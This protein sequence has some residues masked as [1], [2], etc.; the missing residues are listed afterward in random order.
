VGSEEELSCPVFDLRKQGEEE[1]EGPLYENL[2]LNSPALSLP[3]PVQFSD[4]V[5]VAN[6]EE[7][8][9][10]EDLSLILTNQNPARIDV[11]TL[12]KKKV[13][14]SEFASYCEETSHF[15][16]NEQGATG[17]EE[18][19]VGEWRGRRSD[20]LDI[21]EGGDTI[22]SVRGTVR[23]VKNRVRAGIATFLQ[24]QTAKNY[25]ESEQGRCVV[26]VT[27]IGIV[28]ETKA[29][30]TAIRN[31]FRNMLI[32]YDERDVFMSREH[33]QELTHRL[34]GR[35]GALPQVFLHGQHLG[36]AST[37]ERLN[38]S[39]ALRKLLKPLQDPVLVSSVCSKC[40]GFAMLPCP[41]C[42]GSKKSG[43]ANLFNR[44]ALRC[45][46]CDEG[47]LVRC[48]LCSQH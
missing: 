25:S 6:L 16:V 5:W 20:I 11:R 41:V 44:V 24:D 21:R 38:E 46:N 27:S 8:E 13:S 30:C 10:E 42:S 15:F 35:A 3:P 18:D 33:L 23:G 28:R 14:R 4:G 22:R 26:Y 37:V 9:E 31:I 36:D 47:G 32:R 2:A 39:G 40:G 17:E 1:E 45:T 12:R 19:E 34:G 48:D 29:R 43:Q 7:E